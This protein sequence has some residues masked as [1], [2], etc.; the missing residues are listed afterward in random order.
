LETWDSGGFPSSISAEIAGADAAI[1]MIGTNDWA[2]SWTPFG[3]VDG[4]VVDKSTFCG[5]IRSICASLQ[6]I[7]GKDVPVIFCT[8]I[9]RKQQDDLIDYTKANNVEK[10]L[11][12]YVNAIKTI[13]SAYDNIYCVDLYSMCLID[14]LS[15]DDT[16]YVPDGTHPT[17][18]GH[19]VIA[20]CILNDLT[21]V[22][23]YMFKDEVTK[24][25]K[26]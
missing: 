13:C 8:P 3:D 15:P 2:Y 20:K 26:V 16:K 19:Q 22:S 9:K 14:P 7:L 11:E 21:E 17:S 18:L 10:Y 24:K 4:T 12:D 5:A 25:T 1:V 6:N 23:K